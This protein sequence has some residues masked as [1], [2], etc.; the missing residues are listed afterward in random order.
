LIAARCSLVSPACGFHGL[1]QWT[2]KP[3]ALVAAPSSSALAFGFELRI[4]VALVWHQV[5]AAGAALVEAGDDLVEEAA[6]VDAAGCVVRRPVQELLAEGR[7]AILLPRQRVLVRR[8]GRE[9]GT[10]APMTLAPR[11]QL[12]P[13]VVGPQVGARPW[14]S[15]QRAGG[16]AGELAVAGAHAE[17]AVG[18]ERE[19]GGTAEQGA[20]TSAGVGVPDPQAAVGAGS[21]DQLAGRVEADLQGGGCRQFATD[22]AVRPAQEQL[23][24]RR[25]RGLFTVR[26]N[27]DHVAGAAVAG[28][29][30]HHGPGLRI[31][32]GHAAVGGAS[33]QVLVVGCETERNERRIANRDPARWRHVVLARQ[34]SAAKNG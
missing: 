30:A 20:W 14:T 10:G 22:V 28:K 23:V 18:G 19:A 6:I 25:S 3:S 31:Q 7:A 9:H 29:A 12:P 4:P 34:G 2:V 11:R 13:L 32:Q 26:C 15:R 27:R 17:A 1:I 24:A 16:E 21:G 5:Q 8:R 33:H